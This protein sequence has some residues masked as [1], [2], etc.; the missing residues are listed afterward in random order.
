M[1]GLP[2]FDSPPVLETVL[3]VQ[4]DAVPNLTNAHLGAFWTELGS[5]WP[6]VQ[7]APLLEQ[8]VE[9]FGS[10]QT[11][12]HLGASLRLTQ[13]PSARLQIRDKNNERM[14]QVQNGRLHYN[15]LGQA[16]PEYPRYRGVR[17]EFDKTWTAFREFL[18]SRS[19][20]EPTPNQWEV[21]YVNHLPKGTV[22]AEPSDWFKL[23]PGLAGPRSSATML[24]LVGF[25]GEW[26]FEIEGQ[27]G[28]LHVRIWHGKVSIPDEREILRMELTARGPI[29]KDREGLSLDAG[30]DLGHE[31]IVRSFVE[32]TS[33][34][35]HKYWGIRD[36]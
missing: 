18:S 15:W 30:L 14:I 32:L 21:T 25:G 26:H 17:P 31:V 27:R 3:G 19:L 28:R 4:F 11:W 35:A 1:T 6:N 36:A 2:S 5:E 13:N 29:D 24:A 16:G 10:S 7:D 9:Q 23:F 12:Q 20:A 8:Q 33:D 34:E 22:W